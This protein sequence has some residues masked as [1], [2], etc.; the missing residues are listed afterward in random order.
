[1]VA[2]RLNGAMGVLVFASPSS[3]PEFRRLLA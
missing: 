1:M 3:A 2:N